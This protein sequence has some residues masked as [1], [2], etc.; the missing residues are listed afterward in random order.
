M[1][2]NIS[3]LSSKLHINNIQ[4]TPSREYFVSMM[5]LHYQGAQIAHYFF[6][7]KQYASYLTSKC[8]F[9]C[10]C[11]NITNIIHFLSVR[12]CGHMTQRLAALAAGSRPHTFTDVADVV[13]P[14]HRRLSW[15]HSPGVRPFPSNLLLVSH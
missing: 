10:D 13:A 2:L 1:Y 14:Q 6:L 4:V 5:L 8:M 3:Y 9:V 11:N 7:L 15:V 12:L